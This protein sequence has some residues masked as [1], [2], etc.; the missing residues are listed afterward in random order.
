MAKD[1]KGPAGGEVL[2]V[3]LFDRP[4]ARL[5][6]AS[7]KLLQSTVGGDRIRNRALKR[8]GLIRLPRALARAAGQNERSCRSIINGE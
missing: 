2:Q 4:E 5:A 3:G 1:E 6:R 7:A 8:L